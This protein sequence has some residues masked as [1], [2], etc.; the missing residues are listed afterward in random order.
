MTAAPRRI[1]TI[2]D[3]IDADLQQPLLPGIVE[4]ST[5]IEGEVS[6][7]HRGAAG[8]FRDHIDELIARLGPGHVAEKPKAAKVEEEAPKKRNGERA[9]DI[10]QSLFERAWRRE[11]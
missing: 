2:A 1:G 11:R 4:S 6:N 8:S 10:H 5:K 3:E 9:G 7:S